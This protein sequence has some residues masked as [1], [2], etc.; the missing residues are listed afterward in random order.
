MTAPDAFDGALHAEAAAAAHGRAEGERCGRRAAR[1]LR[2]HLTQGTRR[3][4]A[5]AGHAEGYTAAVQAGLEAGVCCS[6]AFSA[7]DA[8]P[9]GEAGYYAGAAAAWLTQPQLL[10]ARRGRGPRHGSEGLLTPGVERVAVRRAWWLPRGSCATWP[11]PASMRSWRRRCWR[12]G[13][14]S[15]R[16]RRKRGWRRAHPA[17]RGE[18][19]RP[20]AESSVFG[21]LLVALQ[22]GHCWARS[23]TTGHALHSH[24]WL[25]CRLMTFVVRALAAVEHLLDDM[26]RKCEVAFLECHCGVES[27]LGRPLD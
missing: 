9:G 22:K 4:G 7:A 12:C 3:A 2:T 11:P 8:P 18:P 14:R 15:A 13:W 27:R 25:R 5:A 17:S 6:G 1:M 16:R 20:A 26:L 10:S 24:C 19:R 23:S 21:L